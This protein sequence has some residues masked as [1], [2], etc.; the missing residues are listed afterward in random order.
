ML[1]RGRFAFDEALDEQEVIVW[2]KKS[3]VGPSVACCIMTGVDAYYE[4][5]RARGATIAMDLADRAFG[6]RDVRVVDP[7]G[8]R[9][10]FGEAL[11][12]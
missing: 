12:R 10:G 5:C 9:I 8:N 6:V 7:S 2:R 4:A 1:I 11:S 3:G